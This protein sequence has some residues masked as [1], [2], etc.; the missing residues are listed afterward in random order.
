ML[1]SGPPSSEVLLQ[2]R[3][4]LRE[5]QEH[6]VVEELVDRHVLAEPFASPH[7]Q[8]E[9][10]CE[11]RRRRRLEWPQEDGTVQ[12]VTRD[13]LPV[14]EHG[15][16]HRLPRGVCP[17][18]RLEAEGLHRGQVRVDHVH[19]APGL[20]QVPHD[21]PTPPR[22]DVVDRG[23]A[24]R[25]ALDLR[26]LHRLHEPGRRQQ[27][28]RVR[29]APRRGDDLATSAH[30]GVLHQRG[31]ED[32]ELA[33]ADLLV[34]QRPLL[35]G[36]LEALHQALLALPEEGLVD[37]ARQGVV[38]EHVGAAALR[39]EGPDRPGR[40]QVP[41][42]VLREE[43][44]HAPR[45][46][47]D[48]HPPLL[49]VL[50]EALLQRLRD[51]VQLV[52]LVRR[53]GEALERARLHHG[54]AELDHGVRD[55]DLE[56]AVEPSEVVED[57]VQVDLARARHD[58]LAALLDL[59]LREGVGLVDLAE[60]VDHLRQLRGLQRLYRDLDHGGRRE[61]QG[62]KD[63]DVLAVRGGR[64]GGGLPDGA[65][66]AADQDPVPG[67]HV[68]NFHPVAAFVDPQ[69]LHFAYRHVFVVVHREGLAEDLDPVAPKEGARHHAAE[70]IEGVAVG[71]VVVLH[72]VHHQV[73]RVVQRL[74]VGRQR[75]LLV[76]R[77]YTLHLRCGVLL[78]AGDVLH[79]HVDECANAAA[80]AEELDKHLLEQGPR[81][82]V[83]VTLVQVDADFGKRRREVIPLLTEG[84]GED[85]VDGLEHELH[86]RAWLVRVGC[87]LLEPARLLV[88][89]EVTPKALG[90]LLGVKI[91]AVRFGVEGGVR[92]EREH[93]AEEAGSEQ[94]VALQR[95]EVHAVVD[96]RADRVV[97]PLE[98][99]VDLLDAV[100]QLVVGVGRRQL[101][102]DDEAV[103]AVDH[104][105][106]LQFLLQR[107]LHHALDV[108][109][110]PG[111]DVDEQDYAVGDGQARDHL[112]LEVAVPRCVHHVEQVGLLVRVLHDQRHGAALDCDAAVLLVLP[113]V[114][115]ADLLADL[116][117]LLVRVHD[118][119]V[120]EQRLPVVH[121][122]QEADVADKPGLVHHTCEE[123]E[124]ECRIRQL[125]L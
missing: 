45:V 52:L 103:D 9:L 37:L 91:P 54:L 117:V 90:E 82:K 66:D 89:V 95:R 27:E 65:L 42:V 98:R 109:G 115:V 75:P 124:I 63:V 20:R 64:Y 67:G 79:D 97:Q 14:V 108:D 125:L 81:V 88:E 96:L 8:H 22:E 46:P 59:R 102:L 100:A 113:G 111:D 32:L 70:D 74:H 23:H 38:H 1:L 29:D 36:P 105:D 72:C 94:D 35:R 112:V 121:G 122:T 24:V 18:V 84:M 92:V 31:V 2:L 33:A 3:V 49:D 39:P 101:Q 47:V 106:E 58:V 76:T 6:R 34:A 4:L 7:L 104:E 110:Q 16:A 78:G 116:P 19:G 25:R 60:A 123:V 13:Q 48:L 71:P 53:L 26:E 77:V 57:A 87:V 73:P 11:V 120:H 21:V 93:H 68:A 41:V 15:L 43:V 30:H 5:L 80:L 61:P 28:R 107:V 118:E 50:P 10:P 99:L 85:L 69:V 17:Q 56:V 83:E 55:L 86:E 114:R 40:E 62:P 119:Q 44:A 12:G 51:H